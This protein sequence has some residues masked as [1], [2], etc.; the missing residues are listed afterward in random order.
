MPRV[1]PAMQDPGRVVLA[2]GPG[3]GLKHWSDLCDALGVVGTQ[4]TQLVRRIVIQFEATRVYG[5][6]DW[7]IHWPCATTVWG[8]GELRGSCI[9]LT[10]TLFFSRLLHKK[11]LVSHQ[12]KPQMLWLVSCSKRR[13]GRWTSTR[14][15]WSSTQWRWSRRFFRLWSGQAWRCRGVRQLLSTQNISKTRGWR[16]FSINET[17]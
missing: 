4:K 1:L 8:Y 2:W 17:K 10:R 3:S 16:S 15:G 5:T 9:L 12:S 7:K 11:I 6:R 14:P 13:R